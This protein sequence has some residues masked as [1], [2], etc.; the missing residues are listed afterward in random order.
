MWRILRSFLRF[1][2][3]SCTSPSKLNFEIYHALTG[4]K[5]PISKF[6]GSNEVRW[7]STARKSPIGEG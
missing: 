4:S 1:L 6:S 7:G 5:T 3:N 2:S